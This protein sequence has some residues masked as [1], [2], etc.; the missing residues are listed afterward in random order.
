MKFKGALSFN[1]VDTVYYKKNG[2]LIVESGV[3]RR[4]QAIINLMKDRKL[5]GISDI[6]DALSNQYRYSDLYAA[7]SKLK[8]AG[9]LRHNGYGRWVMVLQGQKIWIKTGLVQKPK[10]VKIKTRPVQKAA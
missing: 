5:R 10:S 4:C 9:I 8:Q 7:A 6:R 3:Q 2:R 1:L